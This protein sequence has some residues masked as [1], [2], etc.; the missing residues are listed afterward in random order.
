MIASRV[1][2]DLLSLIKLG[3]CRGIFLVACPPRPAD[4]VSEGLEAESLMEQRIEVRNI[5]HDDGSTGFTHIPV[6]PK[7]LSGCTK[8]SIY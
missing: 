2:I 7:M 6:I 3:T 8:H 4:H 5:C 1:M